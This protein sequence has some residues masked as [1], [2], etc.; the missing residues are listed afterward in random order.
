MENQIPGKDRPV[1]DSRGGY[2]KA[3][4][5]RA[6][7]LMH[8]FNPEKGQKKMKKI[9][10]LNSLGWEQV[11]VEGWDGE[12]NAVPLESEQL[13]SL[14]FSGDGVQT[15]KVFPGELALTVDYKKIPSYPTPLTFLCAE[16]DTG[17]VDTY[18]LQDEENLRYRPECS[19]KINVFVPKDYDG[20][21]PYRLLYCFDAQNLFSRA[22]DYTQNADPYGGWQL[23]IV[24]QALKEQYG[25]EI[26][27]VAID[28][29]DLLRM[30]E[31]FPDLRGYGPISELAKAE[32]RNH[33]VGTHLDQLADFMRKTVHPL[34]L[35]KYNVDETGMGIC[36]SSM[37][38]LAGLYCAL[39]D[40]GVYDYVISYSP[41]YG[42]YEESAWYGWLKT[43]DLQNRPQPK[44]HIF[45]GGA[46]PLEQELEKTARR[47]KTILT[48]CG[49]DGD[50]IYETYDPGKKHNEE[51]WRLILAESFTRLLDL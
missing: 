9:R 20:S 46:D 25:K 17:H 40:L 27:V 42:L 11:K 35:E 41:A 6:A 31:L 47:M 21:R 16:E 24:L 7:S 5:E 30:S 38:G 37:G 26:L 48:D 32:Q 8:Y 49:Y 22:G 4:P 2:A 19:K 14:S 51:S 10:F 12:G 28:N 36:G 18:V 34:I 44:L 29:S 3:V 43:L 33:L 13:Q 1:E 50:K 39:R 15:G 45:C 23:D